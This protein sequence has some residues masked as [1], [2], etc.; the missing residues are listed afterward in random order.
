[1]RFLI[2][3]KVLLI[4]F[5]GIFGLLISIIYNYQVSE[6]NKASL[7][8][9]SGLHIPLIDNINNTILQLKEIKSL[10]EVAVSTG[11]VD[12]LDKAINLKPIFIDKLSNISKIDITY[13]LQVEKYLKIFTEYMRLSA[14]ITGKFLKGNYQD[15]SPKNIE[16]MNDLYKQLLT[17]LNM[18]R[19]E[20][21]ERFVVVLQSADEATNNS[22][23]INLI[24]AIISSFIIFLIALFISNSITSTIEDVNKKMYLLA[25]R[26]IDFDMSIKSKSNDEMGDLVIAFNAFVENMRAVFTRIQEEKWLKTGIAELNL[27]MRGERDLVDFGNRLL[28][29]FSEYASMR[30]GCFYVFRSNP[31]SQDTS[32]ILKSSYACSEKIASRSNI[33]IGEGII[34]QAILNKKIVILEDVADDSLSLET[35]MM[36]SLPSVI[37]ILPLIFEDKVIGL[38]ELSFLGDLHQKQRAFVKSTSEPIAQSLHTVTSRI[39]TESLLEQTQIQSD[40]LKKQQKQLVESEKMS[41]LG[42]LVA[43]VAHEINTPVGIGVT[44]ASSMESKAKKFSELYKTGKVSRADFEKFIEN[45][46]SSS[47]L[48]LSNLHR[49]AELIQSFKQVAVDQSSEQPRQ[50]SLKEYIDEVLASL[51]PKIKKTQHQVNVTCQQDFTINS[52]PG[53]LSQIT[54]NLIM[55]SLQHGFENIEKGLITI[56]IKKEKSNAHLIYQDNGCGMSEE[57]L[58]KIFE[59]FFTTKRGQGGSGL[60]MH[61]VYNLASQT[62]NGSINCTSTMDKGTTFDL[63]F[64]CNLK[65]KGNPNG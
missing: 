35:G 58:K 37:V 6:N 41:S 10:Q 18:A 31:E 21:N 23:I 50:F 40:I 55:N 46:V 52:I 11:E 9:I 2:K 39:K 26:D 8:N 13:S 63:I 27:R 48:L 20:L 30:T 43:G 59:P 61:I 12:Y 49:A 42:G 44:T 7:A 64:P 54:T 56:D 28:A 17:D 15:G 19:S 16:K 29:F 36:Q 22:L 51:A 60:G 25:E 24:I 34:G 62:L 32:Y 45:M 57:N 5:V 65:E 4:G 53:A 33:A 1:M 38:I 3:Y 47:S 14:D